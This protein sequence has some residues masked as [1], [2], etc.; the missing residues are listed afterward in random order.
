MN[1][2]RI[3]LLI[4]SLTLVSIVHGQKKLKKFEMEVPF[5][6]CYASGKVEKSFVPAPSHINLKSNA[7]KK[8]EIIVKY[9]LFPPKAIVAFEYAVNIWEQIIESDVPIYIEANWRPQETNTLGSAG[10]TAYYTD[11]K[12]IPHENRFYPVAIAEKITKTEITGPSSPDIIATFNEDINWW[13]DT[14]VETPELLYDF[15][16]VVLHEIAHGLG[17]TG[18]FYV[19]N[20]LGGYE[21]Y[22][23]TEDGALAA[24]DL[25]V[26]NSNQGQLVDTSV[27]KFNSTDLGVALTSNSL[28]ANSRSAIVANQNNIPRLYAPSSFEDGSS[29]YHLNDQTY[30]SGTKNALMTHAIGSGEFNHDPGPITSGIMDDIGWKNIYLNLEKPKDIETVQPISVKVSIESDNN[31]DFTTLFV[32]YSYDNFGN[33]IDSLRLING[34]AANLFVAELIPEIESGTIQYYITAQDIL[35]RVFTE[36]TEAP[37]KVHSV[38][39]GPDNEPPVIDHSPI[40]CFFLT[41]NNLTISANVEDNLGVD[42][43]F[44]EFELNGVSQQHF[45]LTLDSATSYSGNFNF[46]LQQLND[47][48]EITYTITAIDSATVPNSTTIPLHDKFSFKVEK[49]LDPVERYINDFNTSTTDFFLL[50]FGIYTETAFE[51]AAIHSPH[52]YQSTEDNNSNFNFSTLLKR[53][54]ILLESG[55]MSFDEIVLVEPGEFQTQYGDDEFWD[56]VIVEGSKDLGETWLQLVD[57]YDSGANTTWKTNYNSE[58]IGNNSQAIGIPDWYVNRKIDLIA[59]GNFAVSDTILIRFRLFSDPLAN[60]WGWAIDNLR[61][62]FPITSAITTLSPG[63]IMVYPNPFDNVVNVMVRANKNIDLLVF[64]VFNTFGQKIQTQQNKNVIGEISHKFN[65]GNYV[66]GMYFISAKENGK[67]V[68]SR[69][70]LKK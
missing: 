24:F 48:D 67:Q 60:G 11:F 5:P 36:P 4:F 13:F 38:T 62:Q 52:P 53:P 68:Y 56:Y 22:Y 70:I 32:V 57:G 14:E 61:I 18:F 25:L 2:L 40:S 26:V 3:W 44:V 23:K 41:N 12:N 21:E 54:I 43:V 29:I 16:T 34:D 39:V 6:V 46:D 35:K 28:Y 65:L 58:I 31:L 64:D 19:R 55:T 33:H 10:P 37:T 66:D 30:P 59:N 63:N 8:S 20:D 51:N 42:S 15:V 1:G 69:K 45:E 49:I 27:Y 47:G 7:V 9:S 17:F 50:D